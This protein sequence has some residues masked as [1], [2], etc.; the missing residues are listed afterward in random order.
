MASNLATYPSTIRFLKRRENSDLSPTI[1]RGLKTFIHR[2]LL[3]V[4]LGARTLE[5]SAC[6]QAAQKALTARRRGVGHTLQ[7]RG[8]GGV[9][10][11]HE[12]RSMVTN[13]EQ[14]EVNKVAAA[15]KR[16]QKAVK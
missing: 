14:A 12:A 6:T 2:S 15:L 11:A 8:H 13:R 1:Q 5:D 10:Y 16:A 4:R 9:L 7:G 3:Q